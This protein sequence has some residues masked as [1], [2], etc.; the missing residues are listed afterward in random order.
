MKVFGHAALLSAVVVAQDRDPMQRLGQLERFANEWVRYH[1][2]YYNYIIIIIGQELCRVRDDLLQRV[3]WERKKLGG[4]CGRLHGKRCRRRPERVSK[5][6]FGN[7]LRE[8]H[9]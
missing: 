5:P 6:G 4:N 3:S 8:A 2:H 7:D 9:R 1:N